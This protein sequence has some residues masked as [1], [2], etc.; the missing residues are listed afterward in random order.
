MGNNW[1]EV[2]SQRRLSD[3]KTINLGSLIEIDGF[4]TAAS[5]VSES[6]W[7]TNIIKISEAMGMLSSHTVYEVGCG[8]GAFILGLRECRE[9]RAD[10]CD[11]SKNLIE[12]ARSALKDSVFEHIEGSDIKVVPKYDFVISH[13]VFHYFDKAYAE[14][15]LL[16]MLRKTRLAVGIFEIPNKEMI[17]ESEAE[18][19]NSIGD[20]EYKKKYQGLNH[21]YYEKSFF[22]DF[23]CNNFPGAEVTF[24]E[25]FFKNVKQSKARF[26]VIIRP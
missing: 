8:A 17:K 12:L 1:Y 22:A 11:Y 6:D 2:W 19:Q 7:K 24:I 20:A 3:E 25:S 26:G 9:I 18:R 13:G 4:D 10:G 16:K 5:K 14:R 21:T 15:V 23:V